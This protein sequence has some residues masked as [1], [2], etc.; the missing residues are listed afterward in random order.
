MDHIH[1]KRPPKDDPTYEQWMK[2]DALVLQ[3]IYGTLSEDYLLGVLEA[4]STALEVWDRVKTIFL[5][6]KGPRCV[7]LQQNFINLKLSAMPSVEA[8]CL[9]PRDLAA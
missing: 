9:T 6:N 8:Y 3:W 4:E 5:N 7:A 1:E 2:I